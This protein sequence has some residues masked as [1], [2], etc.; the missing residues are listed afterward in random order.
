MGNTIYNL[1]TLLCSLLIWFRMFPDPVTEIY[2]AVP[3]PDKKEFSTAAEQMAE[4]W[5]RQRLPGAARDKVP[6]DRVPRARVPWGG[7]HWGA[8]S[9][10]LNK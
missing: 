1:F 7:T 9:L 2:H 5:E 8:A 4:L 3:L 6:W 10:I